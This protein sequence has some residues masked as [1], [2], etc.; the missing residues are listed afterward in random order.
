MLRTLF[1][2]KQKAF[3][4]TIQHIVHRLICRE[5]KINTEYTYTVIT[6]EE[7]DIYFGYYDV[8]PFNHNNEILYIKKKRGSNKVVIC[9]NSLQGDSERIL[10]E[11][12]AW[13]WQMGCRLR[14]FSEYDNELVFNAFEQER[15]FSRVIDTSGNIKREYNYPLYDVDLKGRFALTINFE[16]LGVLRPGYGYVCR[17]YIPSYLGNEFIGIVDLAKNMIERTITYNEI[18]TMIGHKCDLRNCYINHLSFS[19]AGDKFLFFWIEIID[20]Y[21]QA[22]LIV[23]DMSTERLFPLETKDKVS[24]YVW[25]NNNNIL[26]TAYGSRNQCRYYIYN[27]KT[28]AKYAYC[29]HSLLNDGHPSVLSET[30]ILTDTYPDKNGNQ[31]IYRVDG[32]H[33]TKE[34]LIRIYSKPVPDGE[35]RTDLHPRLSTDKTMV[36]FDS[37]CIG[38]RELFIL[39]LK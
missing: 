1:S 5:S 19:P 34:Q 17:R 39:R 11:S 7:H 22:S 10:A 16:R 15:Y 26:C 33:D 4:K 24:H 6:E 37:N 32:S 3:A 14:W 35:R 31:Y 2:P 20:G 27:T 13:N 9:L 28:R 25:I 8:T 36:C 29:P 30:E 38:R 23:Y 18:T 21:H 12:Y